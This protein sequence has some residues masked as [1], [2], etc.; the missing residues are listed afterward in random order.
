[1]TQS[2]RDNSVGSLQYISEART[3]NNIYYAAKTTSITSSL[4]VTDTAIN[5]IVNI[6]QII[7]G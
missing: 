3:I 7:I 1:M 6:A 5:V 2:E 4:Q